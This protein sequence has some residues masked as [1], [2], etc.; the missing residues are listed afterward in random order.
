MVEETYTSTLI[1][2][3]LHVADGI[4]ATV[5][6]TFKALYAR[7]DGCIGFALQVDVGHLGDMDF[8]VAGHLNIIIY[9]FQV[10][11]GFYLEG[12]LCGSLSSQILYACR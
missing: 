8:A 4:A 3:Y 6:V 9:R 2:I 1:G 12:R 5:I 10:C 11:R 7:S